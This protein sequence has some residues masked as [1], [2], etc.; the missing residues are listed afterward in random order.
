MYL[1]SSTRLG[2]EMLLSGVLTIR[3]AHGI[4]GQSFRHYLK[5]NTGSHFEPGVRTNFE[6]PGQPRFQF[7]RKKH[8]RRLERTRT[9]YAGNSLSRA[10]K[11]NA[12]VAEARPIRLQ[13]TQGN[14]SI[15][16]DWPRSL[17]SFLAVNS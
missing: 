14:A 6:A 2:P 15:Q 8:T 12:P 16:G 7:C 13:L 17:S 3:R 1:S 5:L 4:P 10:P 9:F 11:V